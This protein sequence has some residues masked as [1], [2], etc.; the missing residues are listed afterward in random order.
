MLTDRAI[1][2]LEDLLKGFS[3]DYNLYKGAGFE[4]AADKNYYLFKGVQYALWAMDYD[5]VVDSDAE[6]KVVELK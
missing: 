1:K 3:D 5:A 6:Y 4:K 2:N